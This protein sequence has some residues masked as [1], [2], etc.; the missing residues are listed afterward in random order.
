MFSIVGDFDKLFSNTRFKFFSV[1]I[2][3]KQPR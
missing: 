3:Q 2:K 1:E